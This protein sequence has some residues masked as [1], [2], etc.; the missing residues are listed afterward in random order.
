MKFALTWLT[1]R[2]FMAAATAAGASLACVSAKAQSPRP[3]TERRDLFPEGVASGD[4]QPDSIILWTRRPYPAGTPRAELTVEVAADESFR[5]VIASAPAP[6]MEESDW[7]CRVLVA[8]LRPRTTYWYRFIDSE[9]NGSRIGRTITAPN[10]R[11]SSPVKF[12][13]VS[14]QN[15]NEGAQNAY[16]RMLYEDRRAAA[17]EKLGFVLHLGDFIYEVVSDPNR[18]KTRYDRT[19]YDI[20]RIPDGRPVRNFEVPTTLEGYRFVYR[21][22]LRDPDI[23]D[24]RAYL[25]FVVMWDNHEFSWMGWQSLVKLGGPPEPQQPLKVAANQAWFE[26]HP[27]RV[28]KASGP[29]LASFDPPTTTKA[30]ITRYDEQGIGLEENNLTAINS[31]IAYRAMRYGRNVDL[32]LTDQ[33]SF[34]ME[35]QTGRPEAEKFAMREFL[36]FYPQEAMEILD[37]GR[38]FNNGNPPEIIRM[39]GIE[40]PNFR[41]DGAPYTILG[42]TQ[43]E[44]FLKRLRSSSATWKIWGCSLGTLDWRADPQNLPDGITKKWPSRGYAG[45][46]GGDFGSAYAERGE[47]YDIVEKDGIT[48]LVTVA[49]DRHSF[50]AG[51]SAKML[52]PHSFNPVG[53]A[54]V[55]GSLSSPGLVEA[56]EHAIPKDHPLRPLYLVDR[57]DGGKPDATINMTMH[58]GVR[59]SLEYARSRDIEKARALSNRELSPHLKFIDMGGHGYST[60]R[61][62]SRDVTTEFVCIPR[63]ISRNMAEDG[64][65]LLYRVVHRAALWKKGQRPQLEQRIVEGNPFMSI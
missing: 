35:E 56:V 23:Q 62:T 3:W 9:G 41:K 20:G 32:I 46:G 36:D 48:G 37:A 7:T 26:F 39:D 10:D 34:R 44:W 6:V 29:S 30:P 22:Y 24:A 1:R 55:T 21:A 33:H 59:S 16:R 50:W 25:P 14:C 8:G 28:H 63:P 40:V 47:I 52:P 49:G 57:P 18:T 51:Y 53:I 45:F 38:T 11:D 2:R 31:L 42:K 27:G 54:F 61:V 5:S 17:G 60:V 12:A 19:I 15:V 58:H 65:P 43:K 13:F 64:G 4:P